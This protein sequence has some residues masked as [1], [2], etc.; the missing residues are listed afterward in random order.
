MKSRAALAQEP[1]DHGLGVERRQQLDVTV[2]DVE[3]RRVDAL[4]RDR[5]AV[6]ERHPERVTIE[7][8]RR[9]EVRYGDADMI[10]RGQHRAGVLLNAL[11]AGVGRVAAAHLRARFAVEQHHVGGEVVL[12]ADQ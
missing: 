6:Y 10:D 12:T 4:V 11:E 8:Q 7:R 5:L 3:Q 9:I 1:A 2:T